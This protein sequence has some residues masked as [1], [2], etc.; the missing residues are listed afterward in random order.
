MQRAAILRI[1]GFLLML[2]S[3]TMLP[4]ILVSWVYQDGA[5]LAFIL[6][7]FIALGIGSFLWFPVRNYKGELRLRDGFI[8]VVMFWMVTGLAASLP[9]M[10]S[11]QPVLTYTDAIF[12]AMSGLTT[13]GATIITGLDTLPKSI[14]YYRQQLQWIGGIGIV[15][16][17]V[18]VLPML[19]IGGM[20][21]Y[22]AETPGP[23]K[24]NK[25]TPV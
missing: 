11:E 3:I 18:A 19:G 8:I 20:Q 13:T 15:V 9:L 6:S 25:L 2:S 23:M 24:D 16:L 7:F 17:A 21:L 5:M 14:L 10:L 1:L 22:R 4:P 12:E